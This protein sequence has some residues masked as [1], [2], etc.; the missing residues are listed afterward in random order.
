MNKPS[1]RL[2]KPFSHNQLVRI[3]LFEKH[4]E[5]LIDCLFC[6]TRSHGTKSTML[7]RKCPVVC[8][9][10]RS[11]ANTDMSKITKQR[12]TRKIKKNSSLFPGCMHQRE[13]RR[14]FALNFYELI[15]SQKFRTHNVFV[16]YMIYVIFCFQ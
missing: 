15:T 10:L 9:V 2:Y 1:H 4:K 7:G 12:K 6:T 5:T 14:Y 8:R 3:S 16:T 13:G 11:H